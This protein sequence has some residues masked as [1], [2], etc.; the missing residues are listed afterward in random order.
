MLGSFVNPIGLENL[1]WKYLFVYIA[2]LCFEVVFIYF[3]FPETFGK[4]LEELTFLFESEKQDREALAV[5]TAKVIGQDGNA[6]E[7]HETPGKA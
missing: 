2:L 4:T 7:I 1:D 6:T 5:S 3:L